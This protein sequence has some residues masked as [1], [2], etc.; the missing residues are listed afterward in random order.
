MHY[1]LPR[2]KNNLMQRAPS[3]SDLNPSSKLSYRRKKLPKSQQQFP[4]R[5]PS[6]QLKPR[7]K[8]LHLLLKK[9]KKPSQ[10]SPR[11][12][13]RSRSHSLPK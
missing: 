5:K 12:R 11:R 6:Q 1:T 2:V 7:R 13:R 8:P 3:A 10:Q 4:K 9:K